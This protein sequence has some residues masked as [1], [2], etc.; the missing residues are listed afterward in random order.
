M[1]QKQLNSEVNRKAS[2]ETGTETT[3]DNKKAYEQFIPTIA[4]LME[5]DLTGIE[6]HLPPI[7]KKYYTKK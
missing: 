5:L 6:P 3:S 1:E 2:T 4:S 7:H